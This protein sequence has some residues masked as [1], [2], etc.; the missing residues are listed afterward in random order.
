MKI[1][2]ECQSFLPIF[3]KNWDILCN[4]RHVEY[5]SNG[6][7]ENTE[8]ARFRLEFRNQILHHEKPESYYVRRRNRHS[9]LLAIAAS[10]NEFSRML[11]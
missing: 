9:S 10:Y 2:C 8:R 7:I 1:N 6:Q 4:C 11:F 3:K 5:V